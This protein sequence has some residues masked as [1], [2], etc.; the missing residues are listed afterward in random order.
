[1]RLVLDNF[2]LAL[3]GS[4]IVQIIIWYLLYLHC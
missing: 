4:T 3:S 1:M 2:I